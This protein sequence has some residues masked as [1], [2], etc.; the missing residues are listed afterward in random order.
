MTKSLTIAAAIAAA[1]MMISLPA[2]GQGQAKGKGKGPA[3]TVVHK[4]IARTPDGKPDLSGTWQGG[5][6]SITGEDGAPPL[7]PLPPID[8][9]PVNRQPLTYKQGQ[10]LHHHR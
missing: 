2:L 4:A 10:E 3:A 5:G 1:S 6:V 7:N 9:H 8:N